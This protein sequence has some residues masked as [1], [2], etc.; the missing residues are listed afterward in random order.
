MAAVEVNGIS[1]ITFIVSDLDRTSRMFEY[2]FGAREVYSSGDETHSYSREKYFQVNGIWLAIMQGEPLAE[3]TYNHVAFQIS[4]RDYETYLQRIKE[5]RLEIKADR[6][7]IP[8]E[9]RSIYF[10]DYDNH[11]FELHTG[12][13]EER[14]RE[15]DDGGGNK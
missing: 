4:E 12:S 14:L 9:G 8:G 5:M 3:R 11:L 1:H 7:R 13:L 2:I 10:Y 6:D 15:Y